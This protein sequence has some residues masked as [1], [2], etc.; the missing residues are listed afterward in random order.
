MLGAHDLI[1]LL[2][3]EP[4]PREG[5]YYR[6]S[7]R[8]GLRVPFAGGD[9]SA[10]TAIYYLLTA[11][12]FSALHRLPLDE[13]YHFY[14]GSPVELLLL[15]PRD[16]RVVMLG[17]DLHA[18][19]VPQFVVAAGVWQGSQVATGGEFALLGTTVAPGFEFSDYQPAEHDNLLAEYPL[20]AER[21]RRLTVKTGFGDDR[22]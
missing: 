9:A 2:Q 10:G 19:Q 3:L 6:E 13:V 8:S 20:F 12:T 15:G 7:Y 21:I 5:G 16:G 11:D 4:L 22:P 18:G 14:L 17:N 1:Q